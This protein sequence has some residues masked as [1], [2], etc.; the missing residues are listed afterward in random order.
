M[1]MDTRVKLDTNFTERLQNIKNQIEVSADIDHDRNKSINELD[2]FEKEVMTIDWGNAN[3]TQRYYY[4]TK[5]YQLYNK[6][7]FCP[8]KR[9]MTDYTREKG[10]DYKVPETDHNRLDLSKC[11]ESNEPYYSAIVRSLGDNDLSKDFSS[12]LKIL[13]RIDDKINELNKKKNRNN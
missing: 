13:K 2:D 9:S 8:P 5:L 12:F 4:R 11:P 10:E 3:Y 7:N 1:D 6:L